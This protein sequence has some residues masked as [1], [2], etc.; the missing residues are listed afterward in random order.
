MLGNIIYTPASTTSG[1]FVPYNGAISNVN[2]GAFSLSATSLKI[3]NGAFNSQLTTAALTANRVITFQN[4]TGTVA[5]LSDLASYVPY[6]GATADVDLGTYILNAK[7][8][9]VKG[10]AGDGHL[11]LKHQSANFKN[12]GNAEG[13]FFLFP[14]PWKTRGSFH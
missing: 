8:V 13:K 11:G 4:A 9:N 2:L 5:F 14:S 7:T 6:T 10:T 3:I 1:T 12:K